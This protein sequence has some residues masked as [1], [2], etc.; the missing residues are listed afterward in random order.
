MA[1]L[2]RQQV[3]DIAKNAPGHPPIETVLRD[4]QNRGHIIEGLNDNQPGSTG[5]PTQEATPE[6]PKSI[7]GFAGNVLK[8]GAQ[9]IG[10]TAKG[11]YN[12]VR[13]PQQTLQGIGD[14]L[15]GEVGKVI[16]GAANQQQTQTAD[17]V[18]KFYKDRYGGMDQI[19]NTL[20]NDPI[21]A[22]ADVSVLAGGVEGIASK[23]GL[24]K[25]ASTASNIARFT[26]PL[27]VVTEATKAAI[28]TKLADR[29]AT[30]LYETSLKPSTTFSDAERAA[31]VQTGLKEGIHISQAGL[32]HTQNTIDS[33]NGEISKMIKTAADNGSTVSTHEVATRLNDV[34]DF[35]KQTATP[36]TYL[37]QLDSLE[38]EFL[39]SHGSTL[40]IDVAQ[41]IKQNTY[42]L[43]RKSYGE[44]K[45]ASVEG[46][47]AIARGLKEEIVK[48]YPQVGELNAKDTA[49][50]NLED[51]LSKAVARSGNRQL[52]GIKE[53]AS[54]VNPKFLASI[55][56]DNPEVKSTI[57]ILLK[58]VA[59]K[60]TSKPGIVRKAITPLT[61]SATIGKQANQQ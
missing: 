30:R 29:T 26:D 15:V 47:K 46:Q 6:Q 60:T 18:N 32:E 17:T 53:L 10:D 33:I 13:H 52:F 49:L 1:N 45:T 25:V 44:M 55:V 11:L 24:T 12:S 38:K 59:T 23:A 19:K 43:L 8:S 31:Q 42:T 34:R 54:L 61:R 16:P 56:L 50:I 48:Q 36:Q 41:K 20:Y 21:G 5:T 28:P 40:P 14:T 9:F 35:F 58:K 22:A 7:G 39:S 27:Q 51:S 37:D 2:T 57:A 4:L 3:L